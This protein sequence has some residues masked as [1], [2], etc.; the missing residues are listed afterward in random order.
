MREL[1]DLPADL[2]GWW[3]GLNAPEKREGIQGLGNEF[4][5]LLD[6]TTYYVSVYFVFFLF[7]SDLN[8]DY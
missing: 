8:N 6:W 4:W 7:L 3:E 5:Y 1:N 2:N